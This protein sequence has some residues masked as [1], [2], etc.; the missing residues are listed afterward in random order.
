MLPVL[1]LMQTMPTFVYL[2]PILIL[3]G[4]GAPGLIV[5]IIFAIPTRCA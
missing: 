4:L 1:D 3:F 2:I 5:T